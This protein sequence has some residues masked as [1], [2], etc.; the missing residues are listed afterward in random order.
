[1]FKICDHKLKVLVTGF[2]SLS[3]AKQ[4]AHRYAADNYG[5]TYFVCNEQGEILAGFT[6]VV[7]EMP[8]D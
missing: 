3:Q 1:M 7:V 6:L 8:I 5:T 4:Q 2:A